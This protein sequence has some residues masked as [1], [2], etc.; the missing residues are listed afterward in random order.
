MSNL[1]SQIY[2]AAGHHREAMRLHED[3]LRLVVEGDD[4]DDK[5]PDTL[6]AKA[7]KHHLLLLQTA[8]QRLGGWDKDASTY[9]K[10]VDQL[11]T[12]P[13]YK[14]NPLFKGF[15]STDKWNVKDK[16]D[17]TNEFTKP[18]DWEFLDPATLTDRGEVV[19]HLISSKNQ[20]SGFRRVT[21]N[22]GLNSTYQ[23]SF[24]EDMKYDDIAGEDMNRLRTAVLA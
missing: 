6:T 21:S 17:A 10:L 19:K 12:M 2:T 1:L 16:P 18:V 3:I 20:R 7:V 9:K 15:H 13:E 14:S 24:R 11:L 8:Y 4:G 23:G 5:T 22:W